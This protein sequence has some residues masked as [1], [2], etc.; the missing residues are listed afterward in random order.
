M[1]SIINN[2]EVELESDILAPNPYI[3]V[4]D[5]EKGKP[6]SGAM[7]YF[8][9]AG[10][11]PQVEANQKKVYMLQENGSAVAIPQPVITGA[12]GIP[13]YNEK[14]AALAC[15]GAFSYKVLDSNGS[16]KY[17]LPKV[18]TPNLLGYSGVIA[19]EAQTYTGSALI[20]YDIIEAST[21]TFYSSSIGASTP[22]NGALMRKD[23]DYEVTSATQIT[24]ITSYPVNT[25]I[26][27]RQM[28]PTGDII[29]VS[30]T[31]SSLI[32]IDTIIEAKTVDLSLGDTVTI[33]GE[34]VIGDGL[35]GDKYYCV[36]GGTGTAD[37]E[38]FIDLVNGLQLQ[39]IQNNTVLRKY[40]QRSSTS[41]IASG[42]LTIDLN[43]S[44]EQVVTLNQNVTNVIFANVNARAGATNTC[45]LKVKQSAG[46]LYD[47]AWPALIKWA[48]GVAPSV[49]QTINREDIFGFVT[50]DAGTTWYGAVMGQ[51]YAV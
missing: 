26:L 29:S 48:G 51:D 13:M 30:G 24:L 37:D 3:Y 45:T 19:E 16:Q 40:A 38:N 41:P 22:F 20:S 28:D 2:G 46:T 14:V 36:A 9:I 47:I 7:L 17:Y 5:P 15:D 34:N 8:G 11:D 12:G 23:V 44:S 10:R 33:N 27:G 49:T 18:T 32:V 50:Y 25:V 1:A 6:L 39:L 4:A 43:I 35:G 42:D 21:A 31:V